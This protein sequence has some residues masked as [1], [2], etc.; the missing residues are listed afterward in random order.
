[1]AITSARRLIPL[2]IAT[3][4]ASGVISLTTSSAFAAPATTTGVTTDT[5]DPGSSLITTHSK[6]RKLEKIGTKNSNT[7][8]LDKFS[9]IPINNKPHYSDGGVVGP[10]PNTAGSVKI[11][12]LS[13]IRW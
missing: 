2:L 5:D 6:H 8:R 13:H 9:R 10:D 12:A 11:S 7:E 3:T 1:M 4:L